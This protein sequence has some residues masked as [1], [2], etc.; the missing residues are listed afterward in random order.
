MSSRRDWV[1]TAQVVEAA[2]VHGS[3]L[4]RWRRRGLLPEPIFVSLGKRGRTQRWPPHAPAQAAWVKA[5]LED[6]WT[7]DEITA[8][9]ERGEFK[10]SSTGL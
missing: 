5:R 1:T 3:T 9:L 2:G 4:G 7:F 6:G 10:P 8:A